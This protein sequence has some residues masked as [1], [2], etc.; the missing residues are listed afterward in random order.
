MASIDDLNR[1]RTKVE[2]L[3]QEASRAA[4]ALEQVMGQLRTEFDCKTLAEAE[5]LLETLN[6][7][8]S[9]AE[10]TFNEAYVKFCHD[11]SE[12][13]AGAEGH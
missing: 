3:K 2:A 13:V 10:Q 4:G 7:E 11:N 8:A 5:T 1:L 12:L 9:S 6:A